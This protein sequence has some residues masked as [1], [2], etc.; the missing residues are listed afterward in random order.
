M[1]LSYCP[2]CGT[3]Y[4]K[5]S[6]ERCSHDKCGRA[7]LADIPPVIRCIDSRGILHIRESQAAEVSDD[8]LVY[9]NAFIDAEGTRINPERVRLNK[10]RWELK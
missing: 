1:N 9:G 4:V 8:L 6:G 10:G 2:A 5:P 3:V 7:V